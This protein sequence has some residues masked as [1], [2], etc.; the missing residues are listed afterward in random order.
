MKINLLFIASLFFLITNTN[1]QKISGKITDAAGKPQEFVNVMLM[2]LPDSTM[3]KGAV[4][5]TDGSYSFEHMDTGKY[6]IN[7]SFVGFKN[8]STKVFSFDAKNDLV[9]ENIALKNLDEELKTV[10]ITT[11]KPV[12]EVKPDRIVF[13]VEASPSA[14]GLNGLELLRR[15]PAVTIDKDENVILKGKNNV[16]IWINGKPSPLSGTDLAA[17]LKSLLSDDIEAIEIISNPGAKFD[18]AGTGGIIN[19]K[20]KKNRKIGTNGNISLGVQQGITPK[21]DG[22]INLNYRDNKI[23]VFGSYSHNRGIYHND[24]NLKTTSGD[25]TY[26]QTGGQQNE[27]INNNAKI[28]ADYFLNSK[29][30]LGFIINGGY[31]DNNFTASNKTYIART[32]TGKTDSIL[33]AASYNSGFNSNINYNLN[34]RFAD[35]SGH[36]FG[37]DADYGNF[38]NH[39]NSYLP[40]YYSDPTELKTLTTNISKNNTQTVVDIKTIKADYEQKLGKGKIGFGAKYSDVKTDNNLDY[41]NVLNGSD[42]L[43]IDR[44]NNF[45]YKEQVTAGYINWNQQFGK[46]FG[47]QLGLRAENTHS[48]GNLT[49]LKTINDNNVDTSYLNF[50]PSVAFSFT[51]NENNAFNLTYRHSIDRPD[52]KSLNP[53]EYQL[54]ELIFEKGNPMLRP[55]YSHSFD[56]TYTYHQSATFGIGY[57]RTNDF[58]TQITD[59]QYDAQ[60]NKYRF[61]VTKRN[62]AK[63]D[64]YYISIQSPL[65]ITKWWNG[66]VNTWFNYDNIN[67]DLGEGKIISIMRPE[68]GIFTQQTFTLG[69]GWT[70][71]ANGWWSTGG[72]E[73]SFIARPQ[74]VAGIAVQKKFWDG[75]GSLKLAFDDIF[76]TSHWSAVSTVGKLTIDGNGT[77]EGQRLKLN[78]SYRFGSKQI[79][80]ARNHETGIEAEKKRVKS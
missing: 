20:L 54:N 69:K 45:I 24:L 77:W 75:D 14:T 70:A 16:A 29:N 57:A 67:A 79:K 38:T 35:T 53:F 12:F 23:N 78:F 32:S 40:N 59:Q 73:G 60:L 56:L 50:F 4:S 44:T 37:M 52:Y 33:N 65:P 26:T 39:G 61:F 49:A 55:Q 18:A 11:R 25:T 51:K 6:Y 42:V 28:G 17:F 48:M 80:G 1:A 3:K 9:M 74:G 2:H 22:S 68:A 43:N 8:N 13:N 27:N 30:T 10:T 41:Y 21:A 63:F 62:L 71:E 72:L 47:V 7:A 64:H 5:E 76:H 31:G 15:S 19:I 58:I 66:F 34:Y 46:K 36:E